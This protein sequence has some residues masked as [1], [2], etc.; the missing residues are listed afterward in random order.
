M[1]TTYPAG[2]DT[3]ANPASTDTLNNPP[4][5]Q[6]HSNANDAI[7]AIETVLGTNP[8]G[9]FP[10]VRQR[11]ED[12]ETDVA[13]TSSYDAILEAY[14]RNNVDDTTLKTMFQSGGAAVGGAAIVN[15]A[16]FGIGLAGLMSVGTLTTD[17]ATGFFLAATGTASGQY[18]GC[19]GPFIPG[20]RDFW[21]GAI[22]SLEQSVANQSFFLGAQTAG[23]NFQG[24][25]NG[26]IGMRVSGI[27][28]YEFFTDN[29]GVE[30]TFDTTVVPTAGVM[31]SV[32]II[33][34]GTNIICYLDGTIVTTITT[35]VPAGAL[36]PC[37]GVR[38]ATTT[39]RNMRF[40]DF[41]GMIKN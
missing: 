29:G 13:A 34:S 28:N 25:T 26:M 33:R 15:G 31:H 36:V 17:A 27:G 19:A 18:A 2:V 14:I 21:I 9:G 6:Q 12:I 4:H 38:T 11:I 37:I 5:D 40:S 35:N 24:S 7:E 22:V 39:N 20:G 1:A 41:S 3:L 8:Q 30:S 32:L 23:D 10:T 16:R